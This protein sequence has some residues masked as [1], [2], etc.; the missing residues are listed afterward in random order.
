MVKYTLKRIL[1]FI[2]VI[3]AVAFVIFTILYLT[4]GDP[5][6]IMMPE[7]S[8]EELEALRV[9]LG[10]NGGYLEQLVRFMKNTFINFDLGTSFISKTPVMGDILSRLPITAM[11]AFFCMIVQILAGIPFGI[12]AA[13]HRNQWQD[14]LCSIL[15]MLGVSVPGFVLAFLL[16]LIFSLKLKW[17]PMYGFS[18]W[19][20][21]ILPFVAASVPSIGGVAKLM[22]SDLLEVIRSDYVVTARSKGL[23]E[24]SILYKHAVPNSLIPVITNIG[25]SF[26][27]SLGGTVIIETTFSIPGVGLYIQKAISN[28]DYPAIRGSVLVLALIFC[29]IILIVDLVYAYIDPRIKAQYERRGKKK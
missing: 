10:I 3:I 11:I 16:L 1:N 22:R 8:P 18:S 19:E 5:A 15:A 25:T 4:P 28:R 17:L 12:T 6:L 9:K 26:G 27:R 7:G 23:S 13:T 20:H 29:V 14:Y 2:P 21:Y 24:R